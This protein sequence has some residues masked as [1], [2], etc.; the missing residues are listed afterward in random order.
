[1]KKIVVILFGLLLVHALPT[2]AATNVVKTQSLDI[3]DMLGQFFFLDAGSSGGSF[4]LTTG[5]RAITR[6]TVEVSYLQ[7]WMAWSDSNVSAINPENE[8]I[9]VSTFRINCRDKTYAPSSYAT[10]G[11]RTKE[12]LRG[13][14]YKWGDYSADDFMASSDKDR[15]TGYMQRVCD[16][17]GQF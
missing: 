5:I 7:E 4:M 11:Y 17:T 8:K 3:S 14:A 12:F 2:N 10:D 15:M 16:F 13:A 1:M 9:E 6:N